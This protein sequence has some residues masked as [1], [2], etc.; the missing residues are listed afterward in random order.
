MKK[1]LHT[2]ISRLYR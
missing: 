1:L 2:S